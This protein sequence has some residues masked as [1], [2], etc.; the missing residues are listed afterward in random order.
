[1]R[2]ILSLAAMAV[3]VGLAFQPGQ[4]AND[5]VPQDAITASILGPSSMQPDAECLFSASVSGGTPPYTFQWWR[6]GVQVGTG[7]SVLISRQSGSS[8]TQLRVQLQAWDY[9]DDYDYIEKMVDLDEEAP[10][11]MN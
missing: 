5:A 8:A 4:A 11:C 7:E 2:T 1:M 9:N 6:D 3:L 10:I